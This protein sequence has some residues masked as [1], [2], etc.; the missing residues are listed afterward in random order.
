MTDLLN[1]L[2]WLDHSIGFDSVL[3]DFAR[4]QANQTN[5]PPY[6]II[7]SGEN[8]TVLE[9]ALA[10]FSKEDLGVLLEGNTLTISGKK[11]A[12]AGLT[13]Q[14]KGIAL[15]EFSRSF[16]LAQNTVVKSSEYRDGILRIVLE[17]VI[18]DE[19]KPRQIP[20]L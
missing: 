4:L 14:H 10:G 1:S 7:R 5:Y 8:T 18:P 13:Y 20:I 11:T 3:N 17:L 19:K 15:R 2:K 16:I 12:Q 9:F 6:N